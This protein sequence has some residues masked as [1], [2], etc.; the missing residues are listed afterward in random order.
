VVRNWFETKRE[1][2]V[3]L[4]VSVTNKYKK[5]VKVSVGLEVEE[6]QWANVNLPKA[7]FSIRFHD[8]DTKCILHLQKID[9]KKGWGKFKVKLICKELS[10]IPNPPVNLNGNGALP[11]SISKVGYASMMSQP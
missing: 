5:K 9:M 8:D 10:P 1:G 7:M 11:F 3:L 2:A 6:G 4:K